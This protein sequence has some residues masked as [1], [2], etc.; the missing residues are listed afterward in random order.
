M[1][2][3]SERT[4]ENI[5]LCLSHAGRE[6]KDLLTQGGT[7]TRAFFNAAGT[8]TKDLLTQGGTETRAFFNAAGTET[9]AF[10]S[11]AGAEARNFLTDVLESKAVICRR[12]RSLSHQALSF[13]LVL[14]Q[15]LKLSI[16]SNQ[17]GR[18]W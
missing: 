12:A 13:F 5:I 4:T 3:I 6:T 11:N 18:H 14:L 17:N 7:E 10:L 2:L 16:P 9:K 1:E 8:E 15:S